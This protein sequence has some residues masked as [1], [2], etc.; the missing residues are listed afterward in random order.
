MVTYIKVYMSVGCKSRAR[1]TS[2]MGY[3]AGKQIES[4]GEDEWEGKTG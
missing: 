4:A 3:D 2:R 1:P